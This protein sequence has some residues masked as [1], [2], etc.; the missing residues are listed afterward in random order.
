MV[1]RMLRCS[2]A[3]CSWFFLDLCVAVALTG[4]G[5]LLSLS[6]VVCTRRSPPLASIWPWRCLEIPLI[7]VSNGDWLR[8]LCWRRRTRSCSTAM[9]QSLNR[10]R[11]R[12]EPSARNAQLA[13]L[14]ELSD[15][16]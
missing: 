4:T 7:C 16:S 14:L 2:A 5:S 9:S 1:R 8:T 6:C 3:L 15:V 13:T 12:L 11:P 10:H